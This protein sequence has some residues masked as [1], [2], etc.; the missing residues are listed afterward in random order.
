MQQ[1]SVCTAVHSCAGTA[2]LADVFMFKAML[3]L[4]LEQQVLQQQAGCARD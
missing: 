3:V 2:C 1:Q 4:Y